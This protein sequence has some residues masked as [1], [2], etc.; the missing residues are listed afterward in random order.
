MKQY[1]KVL[2]LL[3][4]GNP[5]QKNEFDVL[6]N[7]V[8]LYRLSAYMWDIK[9]KIG[10]NIKS[11]KNGKTVIAY[12]LLNPNDMKQ[13]FTKQDEAPLAKAA[14]TKTETPTVSQDHDGSVALLDTSFDDDAGDP[15]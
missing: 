7:D 12:Q 4:T 1:M 6:K 2:E 14:M 11:I 8:E 3:M 10:G 13:Y 5:V 9:N 15:V